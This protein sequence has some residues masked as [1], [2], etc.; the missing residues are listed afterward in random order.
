M[1]SIAFA[2]LGLCREVEGLSSC[3]NFERLSSPG[4]L[5]IAVSALTRRRM[6]LVEATFRQVS[7]P[8][9][10]PPYGGMQGSIEAC[11]PARPS[12]RYTLVCI[13]CCPNCRVVL[14]LHVSGRLEI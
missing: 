9:T 14:S 11:Y 2:P 1:I 10:V 7:E 4:G 3:D 5:I 12:H 13:W 6:G 8:C